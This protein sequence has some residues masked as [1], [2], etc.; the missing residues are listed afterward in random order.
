MS[1]LRTLLHEAAGAAPVAPAAAVVERDLARGRRALARRQRIRWA[2]VPTGLAAAAAAGLLIVGPNL[3]APAPPAVAVGTAPSISVPPATG[4]DLS[5]KISLI[6]YTGTQPAGYTIDRVPEGWE[7]QNVDR[8]SLV[9]APIGAKDQDPNSFA[10]KI[11]IGKAN[12]MEVK[13]PRPG[14]KDLAV[15]DVT[16]RLFTFEEP[17]S[18]AGAGPAA[19]EAPTQGL[20]LPAGKGS[21]L[22][23]QI[24][25]SLNWDA[26]TVADFAAGVRL[27]ANA[28]AAD[29]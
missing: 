28:K 1:D 12:Q 9:I 19:K 17:E 24:P 10:G 29:G 25:G 2:V 20:L 15:G 4:A 18:P 11:L 22:I 3:P 13:V 8:Y 7:I 23:F 26:A 27:T 21:H 14:A 6:A 16:A 5:A